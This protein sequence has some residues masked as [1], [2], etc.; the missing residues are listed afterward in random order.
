MAVENLLCRNLR[1]GIVTAEQVFEWEHDI[2]GE[3]TDGQDNEEC[4]EAK[5]VEYE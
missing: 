3:Q 4:R 1:H 2:E 5:H